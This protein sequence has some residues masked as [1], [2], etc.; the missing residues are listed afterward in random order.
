M[1]IKA[2]QGPLAVDLGRFAEQVRLIPC[3]ELFSAVFT[4]N[5]LRNGRCGLQV[6]LAE[7]RT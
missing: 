2:C 7:G 1:T 5:G 4:A 6:F 3:F